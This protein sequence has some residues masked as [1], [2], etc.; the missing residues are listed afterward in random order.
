MNRNKDPED[1]KLPDPVESQRLPQPFED[2]AYLEF[3]GRK[4]VSVPGELL[5]D[6]T[7]NDGEKVFWGVLRHECMDGNKQMPDQGY[8]AD[9]LNKSRTSVILYIKM[10]R[11]TRWLSVSKG[12]RVGNLPTRQTYIIHERQISF[13][14]AIRFDDRYV[15]FILDEAS[16]SKNHRLKQECSRIT[17]QLGQENYPFSSEQIFIKRQIILEHSPGNVQ[18]MD[19]K[20]ATAVQ[21]LDSG[22]KSPAGK[23]Q[24]ES[25]P[26]VQLLD[27]NVNSDVQKLNSGDESGVQKLDSGIHFDVQNLNNVAKPAVQKMNNGKNPAVQSLGSDENTVDIY[28]TAHARTDAVPLHARAPT[29]RRIIPYGNNDN[30]PS[31]DGGCGRKDGIARFAFFDTEPFQRLLEQLAT[32]YSRHNAHAI[33][34]CLKRGSY[35][36]KGEDFRHTVNADEAAIIL[37]SLIDR[38]AASPVQSP[39]DYTARLIHR[40][41]AGELC[42]VGNQYQR[43]LDLSGQTLPTSTTS[44]PLQDYQAQLAVIGDVAEGDILQGASGTLYHIKGGILLPVES[45]LHSANKTDGI[46]VSV[47]GVEEVPA[48]ILAGKLYRFEGGEQ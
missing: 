34:N 42:F 21:K 9:K 31:Q 45:N 22:G 8:L 17:Q 38:D 44:T 28:N 1:N 43:F 24:K 23:I 12:V 18:K 19:N 14:E 6:P 33:L 47:V 39:L 36:Y 46:G 11:A 30:H 16:Q 20:E 7:L 26:A 25:V 41:Y 27:T 35:S 2:D 13:S 15:D 10:L 37:V 29:Q 32:L 48:L 40:A 4:M 3:S 5:F